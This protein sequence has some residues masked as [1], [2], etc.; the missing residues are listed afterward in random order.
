MAKASSVE[1][2]IAVLSPDHRAIA[3][4][5]RRMVLDVEP[6]FREAIKW[7][8]PVYSKASD[9]VYIDDQ[10]QY[11]QLGFFSGATLPDPYNLIEGTGKGMRHI[12]L[13]SLDEELAARLRG[14][15]RNAA[16]AASE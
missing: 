16:M 11:V 8:N 3:E 10:P 1:E 13:R 14:Y 15:V 4:R 9:A 6:A 5:L 7:G 2:W 12:K